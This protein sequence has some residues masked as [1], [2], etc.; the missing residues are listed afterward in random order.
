MS[1]HFAHVS[2]MIDIGKGGQREVENYRLSRY[3]C[4]LTVQN[5]D[6]SKEPV[7]LGQTIEEFGG[8]MPENLPTPLKQYF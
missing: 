6:S 1:D 4:Y 2:D 3:A 5:A 7:A 8:T